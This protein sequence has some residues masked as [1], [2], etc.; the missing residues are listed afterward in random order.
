MTGIR[1]SFAFTLEDAYGEG[2][3]T[4][5][6]WVAPPPGSWLT[7]TH[8]RSTQRINSSGCKTFDTVA[9]GALSGSFEWNFTMSYDYLEP[10]YLMFEA[11]D[12]LVEV[13][14]AISG[15]V[16]NPG[17]GTN[18]ALNTTYHRFRKTNGGRVRS[19][20]IRRKRLNRIVNERASGGDVYDE[21]EEYT[22]CV[23]RN[24]KFSRSSSSSQMQVSMSGFYTNEKMILGK[25][26]FTEFQPFE[27][28]LTEYT[29]VFAGNTDA[30][31]EYVANT[32]SLSVSVE[33]NSAAVYQICTPFA[34]NF[35]EGLTG[36]NVSLMNYA[37]DAERYATRLY[38]GGVRRT[39]ASTANG[40]KVF[41]PG[42]KHMAPLPLLKMRSF[43]GEATG[44]GNMDTVFNTS[45]K[46]MDIIARRAVIKSLTWTN[47]NGDKL[48]DSVSAECKDVSIIIKNAGFGGAKPMMR[49]DCAF[50][51]GPHC[52]D[53]TDDND[54]DLNLTPCYEQPVA[55]SPPP[56]SGNP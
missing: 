48:Q 11:Y 44:Y 25:W 12:P 17:D 24:F 14:G 6:N 52:I 45:E 20:T 46:N 10:L 8:N 28:Q 13:N 51:Y 38:G 33:N 15:T 42:V 37:N 53:V 56:Q 50:K 54:A 18:V 35:C 7:T 30:D 1:Q 2:K 34:Q 43:T 47:G 23:I 9:Y 16:G 19:F 49:A 55:P 3:G 36:C 5:Y 4:G 29:C 27:G 41:T 22:G 39:P 32:E 40:Q 21:I 26:N 31:C